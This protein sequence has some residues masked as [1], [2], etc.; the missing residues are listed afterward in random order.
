MAPQAKWVVLPLIMSYHLNWWPIFLVFVLRNYKTIFYFYF[1][2]YLICFDGL[3][4]FCLSYPAFYCCNL[5]FHF[6]VLKRKRKRKKHLLHRPTKEKIII[7]KG[8]L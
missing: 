8:R 5:L 7:K 1:Y 3:G 2:V 4:A 6:Y